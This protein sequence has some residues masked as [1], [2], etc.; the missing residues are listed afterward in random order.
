MRAILVLTSRAKSP[1]N[2]LV[3]ARS[4]PDVACENKFNSP[5]LETLLRLGCRGGCEGVY[6]LTKEY[7]R[8]SIVQYLSIKYCCAIFHTKVEKG[9]K[10]S[11][12]LDSY[13]SKKW[14]GRAPS[15]SRF[16]QQ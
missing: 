6:K 14:H 4:A 3:R 13:K 2:P 5:E 7:F 15:L 16:A 9:I 12:T 10:N 1:E 11:K 8:I